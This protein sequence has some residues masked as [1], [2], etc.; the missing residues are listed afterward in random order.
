[1]SYLERG[2]GRAILHMMGYEH[3]MRF[4][5]C[6]LDRLFFVQS[7]TDMF[8]IHQNGGE[9]LVEMVKSGRGR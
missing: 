3:I 4:A 7:K 1:M 2:H 8:E 9:H 6:S 5:Q